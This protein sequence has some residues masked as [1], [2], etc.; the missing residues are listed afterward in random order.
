MRVIH[1]RGGH[2]RW[3]PWHSNQPFYRA[4]GKLVSQQ[5]AD[6]VYVRN[7]KLAEHLL[8]RLPALPLVFETH[9][10]FT[11]TYRE[12]HPRMSLRQHHKLAALARREE[13]VYRHA[14]GLV[15]VPP[16]LIDVLRKE[17]GVKTP[18]VEAPNGVDLRQAEA[19]AHVEPNPVPVLL[20]LGSLHPWKGVDTLVRALPLVAGSA[21][22]HI[23][24]G[25]PARIDELR[26]LAR[27]C[28]VEAR[29]VFHGPVAPGKR[30]DHM[31]R[32][33]VCLLPLTATGIG[34]RHTSPIK[35]FEYMAAGRPIVV[36][37]VPA[38]RAIVTPD[39][40]ALIAEVG[41]P[42]AFAEAV[43]TLLADQALRARLGAAARQRAHD[44]T[45]DSR[46]TKIA[47]FLSRLLSRAV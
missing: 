30:F 31:H 24:G 16:F 11:L 20:Y 26:A 3:L 6:V 25:T 2:P 28:G 35:L 9:E 27:S 7:L 22:L 38:T 41:N 42:G 13:F 33:D 44:F 29:V 23:A 36:A 43:N 14:R 17:F 1:L 45:W 39:V 10:P 4:V 37:D 12:E 8:L 46:G 5:A 15:T 34:S 21:Q 40:H 18:A 47:A 19:P 32:A